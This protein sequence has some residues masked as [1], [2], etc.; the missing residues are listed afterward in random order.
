[1]NLPPGL[2]GW[3]EPF[4]GTPT[5]RHLDSPVPVFVDVSRVLPVARDS[6]A[7]TR[8]HCVCGLGVSSHY[9][10]VLAKW[11]IRAAVLSRGWSSS[12]L[13]VSAQ[14]HLTVEPFDA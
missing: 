4:P 2:E 10:T 11:P 7:R 5:V 3:V 1:M 13:S 8:F 14:R 9:S 6:R 12:T